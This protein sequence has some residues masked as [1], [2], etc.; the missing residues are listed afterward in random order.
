MR[1]VVS[2]LAIDSF[3]IA[4]FFDV[5]GPPLTWPVVYFGWS[6]SYEF[7]FYLLVAGVIALEQSQRGWLLVAVLG[8]LPLVGLV[9]HPSFA[10]IS[11]ATDW[12][13]WEF[14]LGVLAYLM[15]RHRYLDRYSRVVRWSALTAAVALLVQAR[16]GYLDVNA[17]PLYESTDSWQGLRRAVLWGLPCLPLF[18]FALVFDFHRF[19]RA[20][21]LLLL[22]GNASYSIYLVQVLIYEPVIKIGS[23]FGVNAD[24]VILTLLCACPV[25][26]VLCYLGF[27]RP[28]TRTLQRWTHT[29]VLNERAAR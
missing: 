14:A 17:P 19:K 9:C 3:L 24:V 13:L 18:C 11:L 4:P 2:L 27:E 12:M 29:G 15:W 16:S 25:A 1:S 20:Y 21:P 23:V 7:V 10:A 22:L 28:V 5:G 26:G 6:L 8:G